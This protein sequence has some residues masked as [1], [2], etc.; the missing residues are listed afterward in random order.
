MTLQTTQSRN[1]QK[2]VAGQRSARS[3][4]DETI[5]LVCAE[6]IPY[7]RI[8]SY[9]AD[10]KAALGGADTAV[11]VGVAEAS[12][13][14]NNKVADIWDEGS[15]APFNSRGYSFV[16]LMTGSA[17]STVGGKV[18]YSEATGEVRADDATNFSE[19]TGVRFEEA[20]SA[21]ETVEIRLN[22]Q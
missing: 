19:F 21:G 3:P 20:G 1:N 17:A 11:K 7:G 9:D 12:H 15:L 2:G 10:G 18:Y 13:N 14:G 16:T 22:T 6:A 4:G 8:C 5:S